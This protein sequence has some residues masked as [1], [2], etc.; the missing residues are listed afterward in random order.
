MW[1]VRA[2]EWEWPGAS[3]ARLDLGVLP[4]SSTR[5]VRARVR[6]AGPAPLCVAPHAALPGATLALDAACVPPQRHVQVRRRRS[7]LAASFVTASV[8]FSYESGSE[9][10]IERNRYGAKFY[11]S[12]RMRKIYLL[13]ISHKLWL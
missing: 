2:Q 3:G 1:C 11:R 9:I 13:I 4:T 12:F 10:D 5:R 6:N 8:R 7:P